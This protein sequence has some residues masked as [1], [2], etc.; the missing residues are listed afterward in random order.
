MNDEFERCAKAAQFAIKME[1]DGKGYY[2]MLSSQCRNEV[3][4][5]LLSALAD[6]EDVHR[7]KF[8]NIF[9]AARSRQAWPSVTL[10]AAKNV[11]TIF[12]EALAESKP[13]AAGTATE[14]AAVDKAIDMEIKSYDY[15]L[16]QSKNAAQGLEK[17]F[18]QAVAAEEH[19][20]HM[21]LLDYK[22]Y[23][24]DPA[25]WFVKTEHPSLD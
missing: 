17:D 22:E 2:S 5:R 24:D 12:S 15:Y 21:T 6:S 7:Q 11:R 10:P 25:A 14:M 3:G 13:G 18:Y 20:H 8:E 23:L 16:D 19:V 9:E 1:I 4:K